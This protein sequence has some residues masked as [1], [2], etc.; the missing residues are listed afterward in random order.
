MIQE[1]L[2]SF[3]ICSFTLFVS[4]SGMHNIGF[5]SFHFVW[6]LNV[7]VY[8]TNCILHMQHFGAWTV[9][10]V[11]TRCVRKQNCLYLYEYVKN[12]LQQAIKYV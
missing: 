3:K 8:I 4:R 2:I 1:S 12:T 9:M 11:H 5:V 10:S 7:H 6:P